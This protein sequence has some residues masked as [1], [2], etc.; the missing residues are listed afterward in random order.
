[1]DIIYNKFDLKNASVCIQSLPISKTIFRAI[2]DKS[3]VILTNT[4]GILFHPL[5][6]S[7]LKD[8]SILRC[9]RTSFHEECAFKLSKLQFVLIADIPASRTPSFVIDFTA[10]KIKET[11]RDNY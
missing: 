6:W 1:M 7:L 2:Y 10:C 11:L 8:R 4:V 5:S 3:T 9:K